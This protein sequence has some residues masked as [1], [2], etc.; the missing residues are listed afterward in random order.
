[1]TQILIMSD[2]H[3]YTKE[4]DEINHR[5]NLQ[6][7]IHCGDSELPYDAEE[8][9]DFTIVAGNADMFS[10]LKDEEIIDVDGLKILVTHGHLY[11]V[12]LDLQ[13]LSDR[14]QEVGADI[15]CFGH[16]HLVH[17]GTI[18]H[19]LYVN[20]GSIRFPRGREEGTYI[21]MEIDK[22][23]NVTVRFH[24]VTTGKAIDDLTYEMKL[25]I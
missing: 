19:I 20:P 12:K 14:A 5:H 1:M 16:S 2:S 23:K 8:I 22:E 18:D 25:S 17:A 9:K 11:A 21:I 10:Y 4:I 24:E 6:Y 15:V 7:N 3:G 13:R